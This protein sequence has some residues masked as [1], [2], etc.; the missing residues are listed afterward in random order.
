V[1]LVGRGVVA[2]PLPG[3]PAHRTQAHDLG[4]RSDGTVAPSQDRRQR[5]CGRECPGPSRSARCSSAPAC[6]AVPARVATR[7]AARRTP[8]AARAS[9]TPRRRGKSPPCLSASR[10]TWSCGQPCSGCALSCCSASVQLPSL[11]RYPNPWS[12][13]SVATAG[14]RG[15]PTKV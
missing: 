5:S 14:P 2:Q 13:R 1:Q 15:Y 7:A 3:N 10:W 6:S 8:L 12:L 11:V 4:P 9:G